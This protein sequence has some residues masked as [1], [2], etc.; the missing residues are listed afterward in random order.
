MYHGGLRIHPHNNL[1][2]ILT[3]NFLFLHHSSINPQ[4]GT[5]AGASIAKA[6]GGACGVCAISLIVSSLL[7]RQYLCASLDAIQIIRPVLHHSGALLEIKR[8]VIGCA[9]FIAL[10]VG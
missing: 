7:K 10:R 4:E 9:H 3:A 2:G 5:A 6:A 1:V 8:M